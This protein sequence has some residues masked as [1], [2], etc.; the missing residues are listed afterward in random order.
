MRLRTLLYGALLVALSAPLGGCLEI[1]G[2]KVN[3][4]PSADPGSPC[5][6]G[7]YADGETV[8]YGCPPSA[9]RP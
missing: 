7:A 1:A 4:A 8:G 5:Q 2:A 3:R 6:R 9:P